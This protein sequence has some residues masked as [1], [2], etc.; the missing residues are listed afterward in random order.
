MSPRASN[1]CFPSA[2][3][4]KSKIR[5]DVNLVNCFG[6]TN[7]TRDQL[8]RRGLDSAAAQLDVKRTTLLD[9]M[10]RLGIA[11][12]QLTWWRARVLLRGSDRE[13]VERPD[14]TWRVRMKELLLL[15]VFT[16]ISTVTSNSRDPGNAPPANALD[17]VMRADRDW[18]QAAVDGDAS[19]MANFMS[20]DYVEI[21]LNPATAG[22]DAEWTTRNKSEWVESVRSGRDKYESVE[23]HNLRVYF[24]G[25]IASVTGHYLQKGTSDGKDNSSAGTYVNTWVR[26]NG[27]W[28]IV[29]SVFP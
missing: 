13:D 29:S 4:A 19:K 9:K 28:E 7:F 25:E 16:L 1:N 5:L 21:I 17:E 3:Q 26:R 14:S 6:S 2:D 15:V 20:S 10:R 24:H 12:P 11:L 8:D 27:H 18:A 22:K 23:L